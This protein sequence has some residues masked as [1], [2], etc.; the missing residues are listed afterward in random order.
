[1]NLIEKVGGY[2]RA[3]SILRNRMVQA[4]FYCPTLYLYLREGMNRALEAFDIEDGWRESR[5]PRDRIVNLDDLEHEVYCYEQGL[6][7]EAP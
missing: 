7:H 1:M 2:N 3:K 4:K 6:N 5:R